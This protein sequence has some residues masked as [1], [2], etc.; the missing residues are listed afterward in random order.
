MSH[1]TLTA[2]ILLIESQ[3][4]DSL[5]IYDVILFLE[6]EFGVVVPDDQIEATR[7]ST[8]RAITQFVIDSTAV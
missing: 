4:V 1:V 7:F 5:A 3:L 8:L 2:D 6:D